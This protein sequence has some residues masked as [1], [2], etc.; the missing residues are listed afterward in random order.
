MGHILA[1]NFGVKFISVY[2]GLS[3]GAGNLGGSVL[4]NN[5]LNGMVEFVCYIF[6]PLFI[7]L[8]MIGRKYGTVWTM[9]IG[10]IG[11]LSFQSFS[12]INSQPERLKKCHQ[13]Q[14]QLLSLTETTRQ[15]GSEQSF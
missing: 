15:R 7:D 6:L 12:Y 11:K 3:F 14:S 1:R 8:K 9:G 13:R 10:A 2:Y 4:M 5:F